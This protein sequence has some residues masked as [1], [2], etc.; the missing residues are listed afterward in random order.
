MKPDAKICIAG[1][2]GAA[3][4]VFGNWC[5]PPGSSTCWVQAAHPRKVVLFGSWVTGNMHRNSD[6]DVLV[7]T[8][9]ETV[10]GRKE[11]VRLRRTLRGISIPMDIIV[12]P[13]SRLGEYVALPGLIYREALRSGKV[14]YESAA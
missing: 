8:A 10:D 2:R 14:V 1:R 9:D 5:L 4:S 6:L 12:V 7:V 13:E 3:G 11:S